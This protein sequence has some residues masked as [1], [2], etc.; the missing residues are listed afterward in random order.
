MCLSDEAYENKTMG[1]IVLQGHGQ[2]ELIERMLAERLEPK[3]IQDRKLRC[4]VP[5]TF[6]GDQ[7]DVMFLSLVTART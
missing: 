5:A 7:R 3:T 6:Q 4:G 1:V 2:V